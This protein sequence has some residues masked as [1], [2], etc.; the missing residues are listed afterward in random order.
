MTITWG[1][2]TTHP[3]PSVFT[4]RDEMVGGS[5][6]MADGS[7]VSDVIATKKRITLQWSGIT[8]S[9]ATALFAQAVTRTSA[10]M[11]LTNV[12]GSNHSSGV[13][14]MPG[15]ASKSPSGGDVNALGFDVSVEVR[16]V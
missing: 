15:S 5:G 2:T 16:T 7:F 9:E 12:G 4:E 11:D 10:V 13:I 14:P 6:V 3:N 1:S 8:A